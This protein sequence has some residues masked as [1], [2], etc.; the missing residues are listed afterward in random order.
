[1]SPGYQGTTSPKNATVLKS[2]LDCRLILG[3]V[4]SFSSISRWE[5]MSSFELAISKSNQNHYSKFDVGQ[6]NGWKKSS[7]DRTLFMAFGRLT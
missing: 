5:M 3:K 4:I 1:M 6:A 2:I 7:I